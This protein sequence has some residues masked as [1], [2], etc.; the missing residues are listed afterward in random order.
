MREISYTEPSDGNN[1]KLTLDV[2]YQTV[3]ERAIASNVARIRDKQ[4]DLRSPASGWKI[5]AR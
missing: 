5:I 2:N 4:E 3:A 1:V